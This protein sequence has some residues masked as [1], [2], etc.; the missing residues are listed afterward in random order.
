MSLQTANVGSFE[1]LNPEQRKRVDGTPVGLKNVGN[2]CYFN[3]LMQ[4]YFM[5]PQLVKEI[6]SFKPHPTNEENKDSLDNKSM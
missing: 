2:T 1:P 3:S 4:T 5:I 6:G